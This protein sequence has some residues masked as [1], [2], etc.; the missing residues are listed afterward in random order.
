MTLA[1]RIDKTPVE[2][3]DYQTPS[4]FALRV[5]ERLSSFYGL[6][7]DVILEP[8]FGTG[9]FFDGIVATFPRTRTLYGIEIN[10]IYYKTALSRIELNPSR[11]FDVKLFNADIFSFDFN[12]IKDSFS[13][14]E[15]LLIIG[16]PPWVTN[17]QLT[18][19]GSSNLP[20]KSNFKGHSGLDAM[21]G[22]GNFDIAE[23]IILKL[24]SE[25][26]YYNCTLAMLCKTIVAKNII[27][28]V[29]KYV[30]S[31]SSMDL[32]TFNADE[33][34]GVSCDAGLLVIRLGKSAK[35]T[36][37]VYDFDSNEKIREFGWMGN[38]FYSNVQNLNAPFS[39]D[40]KCPFEWRQGVKHDCSK[41]MELE[42]GESGLYQNGIGDIYD[43]QLGRF[44]YPLVK[45][46]DIKTHE[47]KNIRKYVIVPQK[48]VNEDTSKIKEQDFI[49][50][51]YLQKYESYL[52]A[53]RSAVYKKAPK[54]SIFGIGDY[55]FSKY[56]IGISGFYKEPI[57]ALITGEIPIMMDDTCYFLSFDC[58]E[59]AVITLALLNSPEC[60]TFL[61]SIAFIDSK[62]PYTKDV[63][64][65][66]DLEKLW[67]SIEF[68][69]V[70]DF[71][72]ELSIDYSLSEADYD[73]YR[74]LF[75]VSQMVLEMS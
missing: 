40:G 43:F 56:K 17:S 47:I 8:T 22:K 33:I 63:L 2:Y 62:R 5:C 20:L 74:T 46:S 13:S 32:F 38:T 19:I 53:R 75:P 29:N 39:I 31:M 28:E 41:I 66:I 50:W 61:K 55:S 26:S 34:F 48:R 15:S 44:V 4:L 12:E 58:I 23:Y 42:V 3:G 54:Y 71:I 30:F 24:L 45:S 69:Y 35:K 73:N 65:R 11:Q 27:K 51:E 18:S 70:R 68:K 16:N 60:I 1:D 14:K 57:F 59:V 25:F 52:S 72:K 37:T 10:D 64:Q 6:L 49:V 7:P 21:T 9:N 67:R 36:C